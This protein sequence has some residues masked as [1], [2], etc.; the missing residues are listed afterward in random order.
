[1]R[2]LIFAALLTLAAAPAYADKDSALAA[3]K[4]DGNPAKD[5]VWMSDNSLYVG[6]Y[7]DGTN[8]TGLANYYCELIRPHGVPKETLVKVVDYAK[9]L[10][11]K[12]FHSLGQTYCK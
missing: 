1:M 6:V 2:S 11:K 3:I 10:Q 4:R 12:G 5:A 9:V 7:D 8:R